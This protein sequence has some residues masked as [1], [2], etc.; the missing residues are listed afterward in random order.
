MQCSAGKSFPTFYLRFSIGSLKPCSHVTSACACLRQ[1]SRMGYM[2]TSD[3]VHTYDA[4]TLP[5]TDTDDTN[6]DTDTDNNGFNS[7]LQ[8]CSHCTDIDTDYC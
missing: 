2:A 7:N 3:C 6:S 4:F 1:M 8:N 5:D